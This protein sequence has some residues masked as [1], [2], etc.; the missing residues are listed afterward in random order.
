MYF[1]DEIDFVVVVDFQLNLVVFVVLYLDFVV[2]FVQFGGDVFVGWLCY[3]GDEVVD[4]V[5]FW[6]YG[7]VVQVV[8][9]I[10]VFVCVVVCGGVGEGQCLVVDV[11]FGGIQVQCFEQVLD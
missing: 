7:D 2:L 9:L 6:E 4:V 10:V 8:L 5:V 1:V 11:V 3:I